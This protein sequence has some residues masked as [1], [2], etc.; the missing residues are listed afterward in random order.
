MPKVLRVGI[1]DEEW[2]ELEPKIFYGQISQ[3]LRL[4]VKIFL[5]DEDA[6]KTL[7]KEMT[8]GRYQSSKGRGIKSA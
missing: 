8:S 1:T 6:L 4:A 3:V 5:L 2:K 7:H